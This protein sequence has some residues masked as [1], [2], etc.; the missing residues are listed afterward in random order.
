MI[1]YVF[2]GVPGSGK[3]ILSKSIADYLC[4][5]CI[6]KDVEQVRLFEQHGFGSREEKLQLVKE[7]DL[8]V[9]QKILRHV[10]ENS[11][12]VVDKHVRDESFFQRIKKE[13]AVKIVYIYIFADANVICERYNSRS[14]DERP[15]CMDVLDK[16]PYIEGESHVWPRMTIRRVR[17]MLLEAKVPSCA[18]VYF[19]VDSTMLTREQVVEKVKTLLERV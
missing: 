6:S 7:A 4:I 18:D 14:I 9:E 13:H 12:A 16:Y 3:S 2:S 5:D 10:Y 1:L 15:L 8:I 19:E 17:E 11:S